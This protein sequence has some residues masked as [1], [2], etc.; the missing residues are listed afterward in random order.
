MSREVY[1]GTAVDPGSIFRSGGFRNSQ[2][3][4]TTSDMDSAIKAAADE[5]DAI[6]VLDAY[7]YVIKTRG[8]ESHFQDIHSTFSKVGAP[9][10]TYEK[11][12][13]TC[14]VP[15]PL[16]HITRVDVRKPNGRRVIVT[17]SD[18]EKQ[19]PNRL[20]KLPEYYSTG[21]VWPLDLSMESQAAKLEEDC[22]NH[23]VT[24]QVE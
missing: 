11:E 17:P 10:K 21:L 7:V 8:L 5:R 20:S 24:I 3:I 6:Q 22:S 1:I 13:W 9:K 16:S 4:P 2:P 12:E 18:M 23:A 19:A 15:I 14:S